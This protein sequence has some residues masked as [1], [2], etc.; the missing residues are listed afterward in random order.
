MAATFADVLGL[1]GNKGGGEV[2]GAAAE[3]EPARAAAAPEPAPPP[4][5]AGEEAEGRG[6]AP[7]AGGF[8]VHREPGAPGTPEVELKVGDAWAGRAKIGCRCT[9]QS[10]AT[11]R[12]W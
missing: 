7:K 2:G 5:H 12:P 8:G 4:Q 3:Q 9:P 6:G 10:P 1:G 11:A